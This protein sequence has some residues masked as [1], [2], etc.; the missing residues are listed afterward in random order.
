M[1]DKLFKSMPANKQ[2]KILCALQREAYIKPDLQTQVD[3]L[4]A[5]YWSQYNKL[6][7]E[8]KNVGLEGNEA[9]EKIRKDSER[10]RGQ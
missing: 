6:I 3:K 1:T 2:A 4:R 5:I 9:L 10:G 8:T 7:I